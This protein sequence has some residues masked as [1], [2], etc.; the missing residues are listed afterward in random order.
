MGGV[1]RESV[2]V[3]VYTIW[4]GAQCFSKCSI[5]SLFSVRPGCSSGQFSVGLYP[6]SVRQPPFN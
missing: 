1:L 6:R 3:E 5:L 4:F 2:P